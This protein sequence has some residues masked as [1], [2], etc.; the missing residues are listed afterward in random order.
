MRT[1]RSSTIGSSGPVMSWP[2]QM[3][4]DREGEGLGYLAR[5]P[6]SGGFE[7]LDRPCLIEM[8]YC[9]ELVRQPRVEIVALPLGLRS[10]DDADRALEPRGPKACCQN[11]IVAPG[12]KEAFAVRGVEHGLVAAWK[13]RPN[14]L[15]LGCA[16]PVGRCRYR[17]L[18]GAETD[19]PGILAVFPPRYVHERHSH[20]P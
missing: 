15:A 2:R 16:S 20:P 11:V 1:G 5:F 6:F 12:E 8:K 19:E 10:V 4:S 17:A 18:V 7:R 13:C 9:V 3:W 14:L